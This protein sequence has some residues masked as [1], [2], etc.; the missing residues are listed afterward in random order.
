MWMEF[1]FYEFNGPSVTLALNMAGWF[2]DVL[3]EYLLRISARA[4]KLMRSLKWPVIDGT[5]L[6]ADCQD[7]SY[8]CPVASIYYEYIYDGMSYADCYKKPFLV[9]ASGVAY[10]ELFLKGTNIKLRLKPGEPSVSV[11]E[12]RGWSKA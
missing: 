4:V 10:A 1:Q 12:P 8:G 5:I 6:S 11:T 3:V 7:V 9:H 2:L